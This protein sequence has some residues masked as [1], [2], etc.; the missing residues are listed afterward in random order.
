MAIATVGIN[1][2]KKLFAMHGVDEA[3]KPAP[4][5]PEVPRAKL[6]ESIANLSPCLIGMEA[7]S[8]AHRWAREFAKY[9]Q[10]A[11]ETRRRPD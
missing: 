2:A 9:G 1:L 3:G 6:V 10:A 5:R 8:G 4:V 7:C 11:W